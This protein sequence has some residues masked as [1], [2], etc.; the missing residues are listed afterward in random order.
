MIRAFI[1]LAALLATPALAQQTTPNAQQR[2]GAQIG[3]LVIENAALAVQL[4]QLQAQLTAA[5]ARVK[6]LEVKAPKVEPKP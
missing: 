3:A 5:Q 6:E 4:E 1:I 2:V